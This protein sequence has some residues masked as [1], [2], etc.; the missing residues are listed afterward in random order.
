MTIHE[1]KDRNRIE[2]RALKAVFNMAK[3]W[4]LLSENPSEESTLPALPEHPPV[5]FSVRDLQ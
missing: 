1:E 3:R 2:L 5:F 4:K